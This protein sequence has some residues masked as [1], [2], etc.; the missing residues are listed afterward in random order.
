[1]KKLLFLI[2]LLISFVLTPVFADGLTLFT[3]EVAAQNHCP[4]DVVVWLNLPTGIW[5]PK[6]GRWYGATKNGS[7]VCKEEAAMAGDRASL[8]GQ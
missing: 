2:S 3:T 5:H 8:N 4:N 1:M 7:Y 6:G